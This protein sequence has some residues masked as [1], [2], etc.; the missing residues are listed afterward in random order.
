M[1]DFLQSVHRIWDSF[2]EGLLLKAV[3]AFW[4]AML[5]VQLVTIA[6]NKRP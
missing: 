1:K 2:P 5:F 6:R 4:I 3:V